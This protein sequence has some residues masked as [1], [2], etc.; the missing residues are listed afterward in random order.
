[1][2]HTRR[3]LAGILFA[4]LLPLPALGQGTIEGTVLDGQADEP[5]PGAQVVVVGENQGAATAGDGTYE[6]TGVP[7]GEQTIRAQ[8]VGY[9]TRTRTVTI[10]DG[11]TVTA[12]FTLRESAVDLNEVVVTGAGGRSQKRQLGNSVASISAAGLNLKPIQ[13]LSDLIQGRRP[14]VV[15]LPSGGLA[16]EGSRIRIRGSASLSQGNEPIVYI[17]GIR[18]NNGGGFSGLVSTG[19]GGVP[20]RLDDLNP[21][22]I[23]SV[24][25]LKGAAA[26]T[27]YGTQA[28][29]GV[30]QVFTKRGEE[31]DLR[32]NFSSET[33]ASQY[34]DAYPDQVGFARSQDQAGRM[35][36]VFGGDIQPYE[37]VSQNVA[38]ELTNATGTGQTYSA[39][40]SGGSE[41]LK[42]F[43]SGRYQ[44]EESPFDPEFIGN[45]DYPAGVSPLS[46]ND[47]SRVQGSANL[48]ITPSEDFQMLVS[49]GYT[50]VDQSSIQTNNNIY[51]IISL[52]QFS[53]PELVVPNVNRSGTSAFATV[54]ES[55]M[56]TV[57][58]DVQRFYGS[59]NLTYGLTE[60]LDLDANLGVDY[61]SSLST[62]RRPFGWNIDGF[63]SSTPAGEK[64]V[65][66]QQALFVTSDLRLQHNVE[67]G[68]DF[69][70]DLTVGGQGFFENNTVESSSGTSFPGP[71]FQVVDAASQVSVF[72][73]ISEIVNAGVFAQE[74]LGFRDYLYATLGARYDAN[75]AFGSDFNGVLYPKAQLSFVATDSPLLGE[76]DFL[77]SL[78]FRTALGQSGLQPGAFD[79]QTTFTSI[80]SGTGAGVVP[81]NLGNADLK[82]EVATEWE[83]GF[84]AGLL[85][86]RLSLE[87]TYWNRTVNDALVSRQFPPAGGF[88]NPQLVNIGTLKGQGVEASVEGTVVDTESFS[89]DAFA[90]TA[91]LHE[92]VEDLG[93]APP[94]K[95]GGSYPRYRNYIVEGFAPGSHFGVQLQDTPEGTLP[96]DLN[97]DGNPDTRD[98]LLQMLGSM[99]AADDGPALPQSPASVLIAQNPDSPTGS[100]TD[101]YLGKPTPDFQGSFGVDMTYENW[102]FS[103][104]F[105]Y[106]AGNYYVNNL[107]DA[108]R[109]ANP[110]IGKN[111]PTSA[112]VERN[113]LT[114]GVENG[115]PQNSGEVRLQ[116]L[117][118]WLNEVLA[119]APFSGLNTVKPADFMR[120]REVSLTYRLPSRWI[121]DVGARRL[122]V[123]AAGR[124]LA[125]FT[126]YDGVDPELNAVGRGGGTSLEQNYLSGVEAFGFPIPREYSLKLRLQ[127]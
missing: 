33:V 12:N 85:S 72:E 101:H 121:Q 124:N 92:Q 36:E 82:P 3:L 105:E 81:D 75:S 106:K 108:F 29:N 119:L 30:I 123:T 8:F 64:N 65:S 113:Y 24:E 35:E 125:L 68:D 80:N 48:T 10:E 116:A 55:L 67:L 57:G 76:S 66:T 95:V 84:D 126:R 4:A 59:T 47:V 25:I 42:F 5:I 114:G 117:E 112:R 39:S 90:N 100:S 53:K 46:T 62:E 21:E 20:S 104:L 41:G 118:T 50:D 107:T 27:L 79:A 122:S 2:M 77:S 40:I 94:I 127:F 6:I 45:P 34:P 91:Y 74:Q 38:R 88:R 18:T 120:L 110:I 44:T 69:T 58:Q 86:D 23:Q 102:S 73:S 26:A 9:G 28:S 60:N 99:S 98:E 11:E 1:M 96:V 111:L 52:A 17:D 15:G 49:T 83:A 70:S 115:T 93:D 71:G 89:L 19:G 109:Q 14:G 51:G 61:T 78:R 63:S 7:T 16:G 54:N 103:T 56:Q 37:L 31:G 22:T 32:V 13:N 97:G 43:V 87:F